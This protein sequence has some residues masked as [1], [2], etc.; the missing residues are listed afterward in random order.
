MIDRIR[1]RRDTL[2]RLF[3]Y[4]NN[5]ITITGFVITTVS[6]LTIIIFMIAEL[7][8]GFHN[9][10]VGIFAYVVLPA[11]FVVGL[12]VMP[13]GM[14]RRR[15]RLLATGATLEELSVYP[16][17]DFNDPHL[18]KI[19]LTVLVLTAINAIVVV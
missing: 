10:Y 3:N 18:R 19:G 12:I 15:K 13:I 17:L 11:L 9:P 16:R 5:P 7:S 14:W 8:G 6:A 2:G 1:S 4:A